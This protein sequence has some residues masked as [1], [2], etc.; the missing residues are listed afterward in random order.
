MTMCVI[1]RKNRRV[2]KGAW[3]QHRRTCLK[4]P[5]DCPEAQRSRQNHARFPVNREFLLIVVYLYFRSYRITGFYIPFIKLCQMT[6][7]GVTVGISRVV[8]RNQLVGS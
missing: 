1:V 3:P 8:S 4:P 2:Q 5:E 7:E 6:G